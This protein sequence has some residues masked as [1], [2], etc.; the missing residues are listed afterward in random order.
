MVKCF[1]QARDFVFIDPDVLA[2]SAAW[3]VEQQRR[4]GKFANV[5]RVI[6][7]DMMG[8]VS[9]PIGLT[10]FTTLALLEADAERRRII[11]L[12]KDEAL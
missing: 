12:Y 6:H 5:G 2:R 10:A 4:G 9:G 11:R 8:G 1:A 7:A 3:M